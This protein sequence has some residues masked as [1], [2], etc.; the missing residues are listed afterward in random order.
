[1]NRLKIQNHV[2]LWRRRWEKVKCCLVA[3]LLSRYHF[4][5]FDL[6]D[7]R[8]LTILVMC[9]GNIY[10]SPL[11]ENFF[12]QS[13]GDACKIVSAGF[14]PKADRPSH[15]PFVSMVHDLYR[16][17]LSSH[18]STL[19]TI[20][21][22]EQADLIVLMDDLNWTLFKE[23]LLTVSDLSLR[24]KL[25]QKVIFLG[26]LKRVYWLFKI[27]DPFKQ[28]DEQTKEITDQIQS[29]V[30]QWSNKIQQKIK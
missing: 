16:I 2:D 3:P 5:R 25:M 22:L 10:R 19:V 17:D 21:H 12:R 9:Y 30:R 20:A 18:R 15:A 29:A 1:M 14:Y 26:A 24:K 13:L 4:L 28:T 11:A 7:R 8:P 27:Q 6:V 23:T